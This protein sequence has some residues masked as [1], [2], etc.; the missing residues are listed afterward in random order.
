M[1]DPRA[2]SDLPVGGVSPESPEARRHRRAPLLSRMGLSERVIEILRR[3]ASGK[4]RPGDRLPPIRQ[5]AGEW[6]VNLN[7]VRGI[8]ETGVDVISVGALTHSALVL[9]IG[10]DA[11]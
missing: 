3:V 10:L 11:A 8:A 7:T 2:G 4:L 5:A 1:T 6:G 9:D